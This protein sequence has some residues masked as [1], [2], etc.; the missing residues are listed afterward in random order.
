MKI[1]LEGLQSTPRCLYGGYVTA[2]VALLAADVIVGRK[3]GD[4]VKR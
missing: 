4:V 3:I 1:F 2:C